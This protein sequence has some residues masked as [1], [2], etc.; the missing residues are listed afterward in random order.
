MRSGIRP[1]NSAS[2]PSTSSAL[3]ETVAGAVALNAGAALRRRGRAMDRQHSRSR[4]LALSISYLEKLLDRSLERLDFL[5]RSRLRRESTLRLGVPVA[6]VRQVAFHEVHDAVRPA[7][8]RRR[9]VA[10]HD[11][12]RRLPVARFQAFERFGKI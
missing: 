5:R 11:L 10:L 4:D 2:E 8:E 3:R 7:G 6:R 9:L 12:V 1:R